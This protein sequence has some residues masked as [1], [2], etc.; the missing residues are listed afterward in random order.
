MVEIDW[1][2]GL[3]AFVQNPLEMYALQPQPSVSCQAG[4]G[5]NVEMQKGE[6]ERGKC[7]EKFDNAKTL[8]LEESERKERVRNYEAG[9][10]NCKS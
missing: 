6:T 1:V 2:A 10:V 5:T 8:D 9:R 4:C 3:V 7:D